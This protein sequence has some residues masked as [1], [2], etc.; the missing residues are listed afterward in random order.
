MHGAGKAQL[1]S[2]AASS[3][4]DTRLPTLKAYPTPFSLPH[5]SSTVDEAGLRATTFQPSLSVSLMP[6]S[7]IS[8]EAVCLVL[9]ALLTAGLNSTVLKSFAKKYQMLTKAYIQK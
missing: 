2:T 9:A 1:E 4:S 8:V 6:F 3:Y 7:K 5:A